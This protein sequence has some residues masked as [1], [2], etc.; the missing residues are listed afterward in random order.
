MTLNYLLWE[1][2]RL[3]DWSPQVTLDW[4]DNRVFPCEKKSVKT[5]LSLWSLQREVTTFGRFAS[6]TIFVDPLTIHAVVAGLLPPLDMSI[7]ERRLL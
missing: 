4:I 3:L 7:M 2:F 5:L 6:A 1:E